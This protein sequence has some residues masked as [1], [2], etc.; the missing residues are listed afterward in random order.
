[1]NSLAALVI[2]GLMFLGVVQVIG[3]KMFNFPVRGYVDLVEFAMVVFAFLAISYCQKF[4]GHVRMELIIGRMKGR[5]L[6]IT[7]V[8]GTLI[9]I[10]IITV[11]MYYSYAHFA[12]AWDIGDSSIDIELPIWPT[13]LLVPFA[14]AML[15]VRLFIQLA[16]FLRLC[17]HPDAAPIA[18]P[19]I[20]TVDEQAQHE[21]DAGLA[22][23]E[24]KV[25]ITGRK[26]GADR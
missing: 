15:L 24:E 2:M 22:G 12:R 18:I 25:V 17:A 3:R 6:W 16:G 7:E 26:E 19:L 9:A 14:F 23:E 11:L 8:I 21:I 4:G 20:E 5:T 13:K 1:M 10:F